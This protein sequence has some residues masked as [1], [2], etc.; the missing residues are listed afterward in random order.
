M[1]GKSAGPGD[2]CRGLAGTAER[3]LGVGL[4][5]YLYYLG[6]SLLSLWF[7]GPPNPRIPAPAME[8]EDDGHEVM[9]CQMLRSHV[10]RPDLSS[11]LQNSTI[12]T[13]TVHKVAGSFFRAP[14]TT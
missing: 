1:E 12:S 13:N 6:S 9:W 7:C 5:N 11:Y 8:V 2:F 3:E 14:P 10:E 4:S